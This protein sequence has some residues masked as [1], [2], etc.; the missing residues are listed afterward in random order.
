MKN[1]AFIISLDFELFWGVHDHLKH[2]GSYFDNLKKTPEAIDCIL[3]LFEDF[4][5]SATWATVGFLFASNLTER[6]KYDPVFKPRYS[7]KG[8]NPYRDSVEILDHIQYIYFNPELIR[9][10]GSYEHQEIAT[11]TYSHFFCR[12]QGQTQKEFEADLVAAIRIA[13]SKGVEISSLVFPRNQDAYHQALFRNG[14]TAYRGN[15]HH[16]F[17]SEGDQSEKKTIWIRLGRLLD[18]Y[19]N[20]SGYHTWDFRHL[21][22]KDLP[23]NLPASFFLRPYNPKLF[24]LE[25]VKIHRIK[26]SMTY[27]AKKGEMFHLWWHPH[28]FGD[29]REKNLNALT[30]ILQHFDYLRKNYGFESH[31]MKSFAYKILGLT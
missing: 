4:S 28:N 2:N 18:T 19:I 6:Q 24:L 1:G 31:N 9:K 30:K 23:I 21:T 22:K 8:L 15:Q 10:I 14:I 25:A 17:Y 27:A 13:R 20:I 16:K 3:E 7:N 5:I 12:E 26:K 11:H 29:Y